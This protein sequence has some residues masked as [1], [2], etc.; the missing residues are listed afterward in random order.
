MQRPPF[1]VCA[2]HEVI[3]AVCAVALLGAY[4]VSIAQ[5]SPALPPQAPATTPAVTWSSLN[6]AQKTAL[7]PLQTSWET[8]AAGHQRKWIALSQNFANM[9]AEDKERLHSRMGEWAALKPKERQQARLNF[10]ETKKTPPAELA[11]NWEAYQALSAEEKEALAKKAAAKP[12]GAAIATK[13]P[14][15]QKITPVPLTRNSPESKRE[16]LVAQQPLDQ[17]TLLPLAPAAKSNSSN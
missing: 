17:N 5:S 1:H 3:A 11:A 12:A 4:D 10:A 7:A 8:L 16:K 6:A 9:S 14:S 15:P 2:S 13:A